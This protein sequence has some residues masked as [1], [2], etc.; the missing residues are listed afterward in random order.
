MECIFFENLES[1]LRGGRQANIS[2]LGTITGFSFCDMDLD[3]LAAV[4]G[5]KRDQRH[6]VTHVGL[7]QT[8]GGGQCVKYFLSVHIRGHRSVIAHD[9]ENRIIRYIRQGADDLDIGIS[10]RIIIG[11]RH[12]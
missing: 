4:L 9:L 11:K 2:D 8:E 12:F 3:F 5:V 6:I 10:I 7:Y 1:E